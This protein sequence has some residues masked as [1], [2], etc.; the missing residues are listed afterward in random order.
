MKKIVIAN[1][2]MNPISSKEAEKLFSL[3]AKNVK[4]K[5]TQIII[6]PPFVYLEKLKKIS[7]K[8]SLGAQDASF[9]DKGAFTGEVSGEMLLSVGVKYVILGHSE[10]RALG[11]DNIL[12]NKKLKSVLSSGLVPILCIGEKER[13]QDHEY[14]NVVKKQLEECLRGVKKDLVSKILIAYEP[15][16]AISTT[17][18]RRDATAHDSEEMV[19]YIKKVI[20]SLTSPMIAKKTKVLYGGSVNERDAEEFLV[21]GAVDGLLVGKASLDPKKFSKIVEICEVLKN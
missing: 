17:V 4:S 20:S 2:K 6:C 5:N 3:V 13:D 7:K 9:I 19:I 16:W 14:F 10:R 18:D 1:W 8:I 11:E 21:K 15:V 12:I